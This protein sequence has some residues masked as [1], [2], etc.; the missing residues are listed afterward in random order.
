MSITDYIKE[1]LLA[2]IR[3]GEESGESLTLQ[4]L[5]DQYGVSITPVRLAISALID[6]GYLQKEKNRRLLINRRQIDRAGPATERPEPPRDHYEVLKTELINLSL[7]GEE[8]FIREEATAEKFA[9]SRS[10][11][12]HIFSRLVGVGLLEHFPR[13]GWKV[14]PFRQSDLDAFIEVRVMMELKA[15]ELSR[16]TLDVSHLKTY[17][18][19]NRFPIEGETSAQIDDRLHA[20]IIEQARNPYIADFFDRH[21]RYFEIIFSWESRDRMASSQ[22][23]EHHRAILAAM[24]QRDWGTA[25]EALEHHIRTNHPL[26][27]NLEQSPSGRTDVNIFTQS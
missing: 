25:A 12:R 20:Y 23:V 22:T 14:R 7:R 9:I 18:D 13:Q 16:D 24:M 19:N 8:V 21:G 11:V 17:Y 15:L 27:K 6:E 1:D 10:N 3:N 26:L 4:K 2:R 5:S